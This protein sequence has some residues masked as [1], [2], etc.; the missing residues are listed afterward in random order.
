MNALV[1]VG[2][3]DLH[4][5]LYD[6]PEAFVHTVIRSFS[7]VGIVKP[8]GRLVRKLPRQYIENCR[9]QRVY[10][11]PWSLLSAALVLLKRSEALF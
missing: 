4:A 8:L 9:S 1:P 5:F 3:T 10:V 11:C 6:F 7:Y 2:N